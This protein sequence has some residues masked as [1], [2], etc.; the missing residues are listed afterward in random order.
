MKAAE[1]G[2]AAAP[3]GF[4]TDFNVLMLELLHDMSLR[5]APRSTTA[6]L[7]WRP[8]IFDVGNQVRSPRARVCGWALAKS[9]AAHCATAA[10]GTRSA[11]PAAVPTTA[12]TGSGPIW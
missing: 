12:A 1:I 5:E 2:K 3:G 7:G 6:S 10:P 8:G 4:I 11:S 9:R